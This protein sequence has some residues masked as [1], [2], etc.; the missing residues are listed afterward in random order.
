MRIA[1]EPRQLAARR[2]D[3]TIDGFGD[4]VFFGVDKL[5]HVFSYLTEFLLDQKAAHATSVAQPGYKYAGA[6]EDIVS[7]VAERTGRLTSL[8]ITQC[9]ALC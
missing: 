4:D 7:L 2:R 5:S 3:Q 1:V 9:F 6:L 8:F